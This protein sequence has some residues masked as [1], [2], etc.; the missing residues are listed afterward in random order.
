MK[1]ASVEATAAYHAFKD[2]LPDKL[3]DTKPDIR[4]D[5]FGNIVLS[6]DGTHGEML[7]VRYDGT[8]ELSYIMRDMYGHV[9]HGR[10]SAEQASSNDMLGGFLKSMT[11]LTFVDVEE[12]TSSVE[13]S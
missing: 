5:E 12:N 6:W 1:R 13:L 11:P 7:S 8:D 9:K 4:I 3:K 10:C 2:D